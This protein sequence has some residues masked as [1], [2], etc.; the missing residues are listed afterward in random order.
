MSIAEAATGKSAPGTIIP[1]RVQ[2]KIDALWEPPSK[3]KLIEVTQAVVKEARNVIRTIRG[4]NRTGIRSAD[5]IHLASAIQ[6]NINEVHTYDDLGKF[7][8]IVSLKI[9]EPHCD[10]LP[11][12]G[13][14]SDET[15]ESS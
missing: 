5:A 13:P 11:F 15:E 14:L 6:K 9:V 10:K 1:M 8:K 12:T 7:A 2:Q 4:A 3:I